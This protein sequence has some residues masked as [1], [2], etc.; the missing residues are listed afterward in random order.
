M[1]HQDGLFFRVLRRL[2]MIM[3]TI[4][5]L[6][7]I[8]GGGFVGWKYYEHQKKVLADRDAVMGE[9]YSG[10]LRGEAGVKSGDL[11]VEAQNYGTVDTVYGPNENS[12]F[13]LNRVLP[14]PA[15]VPEGYPAF[16]PHQ[17]VNLMVVDE[18]TGEGRWLFAGTKRLIESRDVV[19]EGAAVVRSVP[20]TDA[21]P[22]IG[23]VMIVVD[24]D[25]DKDGKLTV[26]D[27]PTLYVWRKG[28]AE[29][30]KLLDVD[31]AMS[32]GQ[33]GADRYLIVYKK[34]KETR[35]ALY[36][37]PE[38]KLLSGKVLPETPH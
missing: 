10:R 16:G 3:L 29:A 2:N 33:L 25:T 5:G 8:V 9:I 37:V 38:F 17:A 28:T 12:I 26:K 6:T 4:I 11:V 7:I 1:P 22:V 15:G 23:L 35:S 14:P 27:K 19:Y 31:E 36:S 34:D 18:T 30:V 32:Y 13:V 24:T 20:G 21:R